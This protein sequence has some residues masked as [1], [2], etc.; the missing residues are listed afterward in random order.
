MDDDQ[1]T[2]FHFSERYVAVLAIIF[3]YVQPFQA[4]SLENFLGPIKIDLMVNEI[5][6]V[7]IP[8]PFKSIRLLK[9]TTVY[10]YVYTIINGHML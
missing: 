10:T 5:G 4:R 3:A 7:F 8:V 2:A 9:F 1:A 6:R